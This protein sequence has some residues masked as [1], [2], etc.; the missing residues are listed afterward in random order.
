MDLTKPAPSHRLMV[1]AL[2]VLTLLGSLPGLSSL[3]VIDRDE[4]RYA[5]ASVQMRDSGDYVN[6]RFHDRERHKKPAGIYW[7]QTAA[8]KIAS[9]PNAR[10]IWVHRLPSVLAGLIAVLGLYWAGLSIFDRRGAFIAALLLA[11]SLLFIFESHIAKTDAAL[12][13]ASVWVFG[14]LLWLRSTQPQ[15]TTETEAGAQFKRRK[16]YGLIIWAALGCAVIIKGPILPSILVVAIISVIIWDKLSGHTEHWWRPLLSPLGICLFGLIAL[17]WYIMIFKLTDGAFFKTAIGSDLSPK[18]TGGQEK[19]GAPPGFYLLTIFA[20]FWPAA[21]FLPAG[22]A[23]GMKAARGQ[24]KSSISQSH[25]SQFQARWLLAWALPF[26]IILELIPTKLTPYALPLFPAL[27]LLMAGAIMSIAQGHFPKT[28]R[29]GGAIF[30]IISI[31]LV[32]VILGGQAEYG[33]SHI[34]AYIVG[35]II[36]TAALATTAF[37]FKAKMKPALIGLTI[38]GL[39]LSGMTY[40]F[41]LPNLTDLRLAPRIASALD[42]NNIKLPRHGGPLIR[43]PHFTEPSLVYYLGSNILLGSKATDLGSFPLQADHIWILDMRQDSA[44]DIQ[45]R[46][47]HIAAHNGSCFTQQSKIK[48]MN[49]SKGDEV[50]LAI[51]SIGCDKP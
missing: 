4:A 37:T 1:I 14:G 11:T 15:P 24:M 43:S 30:L 44:K 48:G 19:H 40:G 27:A 39:G 17:P 42:A 38:T 28:R 50:E 12:C 6:I 21:L 34:A 9:G 3:Q 13:A 36:I 22:L 49:Y 46:L 33:T 25:I 8:L 31:I 51:F 32:F 29:I 26:W 23:Y 47:S 45:D 20:T 2:I 41:I 18:I 35:I 16:G 5:Q 10:D 7:L